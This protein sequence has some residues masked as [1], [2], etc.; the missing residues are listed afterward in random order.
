M[1]ASSA[2]D[3]LSRN[4]NEC[5]VR[6]KGRECSRLEFPPF[7]GNE[8]GIRRKW[9]LAECYYKFHLSPV[10]TV[11]YHGFGAVLTA[12]ASLVNR[13]RLCKS[14]GQRH[15]SSIAS[16]TLGRSFNHYTHIFNTLKFHPLGRFNSARVVSILTFIF[17]KMFKT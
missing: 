17:E 13:T 15:I 4:R 2:Y 7:I 1:N 11:I 12:T 9:V 14:F 6:L 8:R 5:I 3:A 10:K 16:R